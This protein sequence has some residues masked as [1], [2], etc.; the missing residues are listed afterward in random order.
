MNESRLT[1]MTIISIEKS[2]GSQLLF[3]DVVNDFAR[4]KARKV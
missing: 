3:I 2:L 4:R 1:S